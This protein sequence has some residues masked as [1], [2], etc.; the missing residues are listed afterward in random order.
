MTMKPLHSIDAV[1]DHFGLSVDQVARRCASSI[2]PWPHIRPDKSR[3]ATWRF[4]D[5]DVEEIEIRIARRSNKLDSW[6]RS[7]KKSA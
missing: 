2:N 7:Q 1:A 3:R 5:E 4:S 6:G